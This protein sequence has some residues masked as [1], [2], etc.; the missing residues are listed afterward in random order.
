MKT[1][2][3]LFF[4][5]FIGMAAQAQTST[6]E[7]K[8]AIVEMTIANEADLEKV[9]TESTTAI[10]RLYKRT[11]TRVKKELNFVTKANRAKMA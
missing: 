6:I 2:T 9:T 1:I 4:V 3:T 8:V 7:V 11:K 5:L 10:A